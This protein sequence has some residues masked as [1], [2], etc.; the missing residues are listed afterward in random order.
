MPLIWCELEFSSFINIKLLLGTQLQ[1]SESTR[2]RRYKTVTVNSGC[3]GTD[4]LKTYNA[5]KRN[6]I[7]I[8]LLHKRIQSKNG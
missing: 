6:T 5:G 2:N 3:S 4:I 1:Y 7:E 8:Q